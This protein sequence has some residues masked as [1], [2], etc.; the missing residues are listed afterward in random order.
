[1]AKKKRGRRRNLRPALMTVSVIVAIL[2]F[3]LVLFINR[4]Q[5]SDISDSDHTY[6]EAI[7]D[8]VGTAI[9]D[10]LHK[11][12]MLESKVDQGMWQ[13]YDFDN[14][15][16]EDIV[17]IF[18]NEHGLNAS[19]FSMSYELSDKTLSYNFAENVFR[20]AASV[21]K[22][23]LNMYYYDLENSGE[24]SPTA[25]IGGYNLAHM[26]RESIVNSSN[27]MSEALY[28][29]LGS[30][31]HYRELMA[32]YCEQ[33]YPNVYYRE[34]VIDTAYMQCILRR[35]YENSQQYEQLIE[36]MKESNPGQYLKNNDVDV[37]I[38]HKYGL[39]DGAVNDVG[40]VYTEK[41]YF[42]SVFTQGVRNADSVIGELSALMTSYTN[43]VIYMRGN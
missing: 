17:A 4:S 34:N 14:N 36:Y 12:E 41:P 19:N 1:M 29:N 13:Y 3:L 35:I 33:E 10:I 16:L 43:F 38:V 42:I 9:S 24:I 28:S 11:L 8:D 18:M 39:Y 37:E 25:N 31:Y 30:Y 2:T 22:V 20:T 6:A 5:E 40:I 21:Y 32:E 26:H 7:N 15:S 27:D 23:P